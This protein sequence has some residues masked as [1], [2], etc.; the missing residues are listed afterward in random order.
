MNFEGLVAN[1]ILQKYPEMGE[2]MAYYISAA[3][4]FAE[5]YC[6][7]GFEKEERTETC[8][9]YRSTCFL[10]STP[11]WGISSVIDAENGIQYTVKFFSQSGVVVLLE[12]VNDRWVKVTY[13]GG[14][15]TIPADLLVAIGELA[16][17][18]FKAEAGMESMR[19]GDFSVTYSDIPN[20]VREILDRY[21]SVT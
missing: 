19:T 17:F 8:K 1:Y 4:Q 15:E 16:A 12:D 9:V 14:Y 6:L 18:L 3:I 10:N 11:I 20:H 13:L 21:R 2:R 5:S 7:R